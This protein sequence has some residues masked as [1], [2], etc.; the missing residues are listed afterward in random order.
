MGEA[1]GE[2]GYYSIGADIGKEKLQEM[3]MG[4]GGRSTVV[5]IPFYSLSLLLWFVRRSTRLNLLRSIA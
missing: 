1:T 5:R 2:R 4:G 3:A